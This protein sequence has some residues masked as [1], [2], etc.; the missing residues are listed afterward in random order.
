M[1]DLKEKHF[2]LYLKDVL[3]QTLKDYN[4]EYNITKYLL[5]II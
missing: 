5:F 2:D 3:I 1:K 4:I